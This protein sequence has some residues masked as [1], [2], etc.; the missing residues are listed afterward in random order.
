MYCIV[1]VS[2]GTYVDAVLFYRYRVLEAQYKSVL[3]EKTSLAAKYSE[4]QRSDD[5]LKKKCAQKGKELPPVRT[6]HR[7]YSFNII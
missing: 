7:R 2:V 5:I 6:S 4:L 1:Y 3:N